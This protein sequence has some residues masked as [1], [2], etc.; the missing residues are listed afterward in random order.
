MDEKVTDVIEIGA[1][2]LASS[3]LAAFAFPVT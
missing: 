3:G 1:T 2:T